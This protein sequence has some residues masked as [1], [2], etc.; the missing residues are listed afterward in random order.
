MGTLIIVSTEEE[1]RTALSLV[2]NNR[3]PRSFGRGS[4]IFAQNKI[5]LAIS[6]EA[7]FYLEKNIPGWKNPLYKFIS[8]D[9]YSG[10]AKYFIDNF[11]IVYSELGNEYYKYVRDRIGFF[12][13]DFERSYDFGEK[14]INYFKP[15][16][17]IT[18]GLEDY[19]G[20]SINNGTLIPHAFFLLSRKKNIK[21]RKISINSRRE[22]KLRQS[23]GNIYKFLNG[24]KRNKIRNGK[25]LMLIPPSKFLEME[26]FISDIKK[27][28]LD[29][30]FLTYGLTFSQRKVLKSF[31]CEFWEKERL[32]DKEIWEESKIIESHLIKEHA[33]NKFSHPRFD[34]DKFASK[35]IKAKISQVIR[36]EF[37]EIGA[38]IILARKI[39]TGSG[40][41][42]LVTFTDPDT[43]CLTFISGAKEAGV[44]T[45]SIEHGGSL[46]PIPYPLPLSN[47]HILWSKKTSELFFSNFYT[48]D[49]RPLGKKKVLIGESPFDTNIEVNSKSQK[50][51]KIKILFLATIHYF[52][53]G[54]TIYWEKRLF[55]L[56]LNSDINVEISIRL[57][58][59]QNRRNFTAL[60]NKY[61]Q[62]CKFSDFNSLN[63]ALKDAD[64]IIFENTTA[65][66]YSLLSGKP[67]V[68]FNPY[69]KTDMF[70]VGKF[71]RSFSVL[72]ENDLQLGLVAFLKETRLDFVSRDKIR[73]AKEYFGKGNVRKLNKLINILRTYENK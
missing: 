27:S 38:D 7:E 42:L 39:I 54:L 23:V 4:L 1:A 56:L 9:G 51:D 45:I 35:F 62:K 5:Y 69:N 66:V 16:K 13:Q 60:V 36:N 25:I 24:L 33:W 32:Y 50:P 14:V 30:I 40:I 63:E 20:Y 2:G 6:L 64:V 29:V 58:P 3:F 67:T 31:T 65:G 22:F 68:F 41:N 61:P 59:F 71:D 55:S 17:I 8:K 52:D 26:E 10:G 11:K 49:G 46:A 21:Y 37:R 43:K 57:H 48:N 53:P 44:E 12:L 72:S 34:E 28:G 15:K 70:G 47:K 18:F 73:F 19:P